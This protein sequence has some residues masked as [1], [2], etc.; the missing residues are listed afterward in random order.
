MT[1]FESNQIQ[2]IARTPV[3]G[4]IPGQIIPLEIEINNQSNVEI[5][6]FTIELIKVSISQ[7]TEHFSFEFSLF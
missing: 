5:S 6:K 1:C 7:F 2:I 3:R 4:Y